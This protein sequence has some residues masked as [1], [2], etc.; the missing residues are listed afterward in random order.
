[1]IAIIIAVATATPATPAG[2]VCRGAALAE[3]VAR[4]ARLS[5]MMDVAGVGATYARDGVLVGAGGAPITGPGEVAR[6]LGGFTGYRLFDYTLTIEAT[7]RQGDGWRT[8][9]TYRQRGS[10]PAGAAFSAN[11]R[12]TADWRCTRRGWRLTRMATAPA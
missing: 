11:G 5:R 9:G 1:M 12:F 10:D 4:Y 8:A 3:A 6:F 2:P 7:A